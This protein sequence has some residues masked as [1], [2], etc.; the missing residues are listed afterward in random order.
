MNRAGC[1]EEQSQQTI[2]SPGVV[3]DFE[4]LVFALVSPIS[5]DPQSVAILP[6]SKLVEQ[7]ISLCRAKYSS[8]EEMV[9]KVVAPLIGRSKDREYRGYVWA[10]TS[11]V[12][13]VLIREQKS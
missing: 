9:S 5:A 6:K 4:S 13:E 7:Q 11:E 12:R 2:G 1:P 3:S 10:L 8:Y